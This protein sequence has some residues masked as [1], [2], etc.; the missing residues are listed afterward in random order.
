LKEI[1]NIEEEGSV[2]GVRE[3]EGHLV[4]GGV[5]STISSEHRPYFGP[6]SVDLNPKV[7]ATSR[8]L[9]CCV[10]ATAS[11]SSWTS[12]DAPRM[13]NSPR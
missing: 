13:D 5:E 1:E 9:P 10:T 12:S 4:G 2:N 8:L 11:V 7:N 3:R 6:L